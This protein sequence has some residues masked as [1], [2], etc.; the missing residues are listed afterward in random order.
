M[1][2]VSKESLLQLKLGEMFPEN[3]A[4]LDSGF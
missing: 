2:S 1:K 3:P 4:I